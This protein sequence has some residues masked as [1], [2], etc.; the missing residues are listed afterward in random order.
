[1]LLYSEVKALGNESLKRNPDCHNQN[2]AR[3]LLVF[4]KSVFTLNPYYKSCRKGKMCEIQLSMRFAFLCKT[5]LKPPVHCNCTPLNCL[6]AAAIKNN[7]AP[8]SF[9]W[10]PTLIQHIPPENTILSP[11]WQTELL[12]HTL[13]FTALPP[14][15][16]CPP[17]L[18]S[19]VIDFQPI[20]LPKGRDGSW[21]VKTAGLKVL[22][23]QELL[24]EDKNREAIW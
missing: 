8:P 20:L 12:E 24:P 3:V 11:K 14:L 4:S 15:S 6:S 22:P 7:S 23:K 2:A 13:C 18:T 21:P 16:L 17:R 9:L 5:C 10:Q 1:M 19:A